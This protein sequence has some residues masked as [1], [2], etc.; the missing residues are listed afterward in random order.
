MRE[1]LRFEIFNTGVLTDDDGNVTINLLQ[2]DTSAMRV[3]MR[4]GY[5]L[6]QPVNAANEVNTPLAVVTPGGQYAS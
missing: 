6:A 1:D 5:H 4:L 2:Q 3:V